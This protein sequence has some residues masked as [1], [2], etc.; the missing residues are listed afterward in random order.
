[1]DPDPEVV[2]CSFTRRCSLLVIV[3]D[4]VPSTSGS[5]RRLLRRTFFPS[6]PR[7]LQNEVP[8]SPYRIMS[9]PS[10]A[11]GI[12][13]IIGIRAGLEI[14]RDVGVQGMFKA[15]AGPETWQQQPRS[16]TVA[17]DK[18]ALT[19][20]AIKPLSVIMHKPSQPPVHVRQP[21]GILTTAVKSY[22]NRTISPHPP[23]QPSSQAPR[24]PP[25]S[26]LACAKS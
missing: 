19:L 18:S 24:K 13:S 6:T 20:P 11:A 2:H 17:P 8:S 23:G 7:Q 5:G 14:V 1:M 15:V 9:P 10:Y 25:P 16:L 4:F 3:M 21:S 26:P 12:Q 22:G